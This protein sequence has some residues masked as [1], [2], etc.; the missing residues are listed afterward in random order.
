M[1]VTYDVCCLEIHYSAN[2]LT[3][4]CLLGTGCGHKMGFHIAYGAKITTQ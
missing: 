3:G 2:E 4:F 1:L